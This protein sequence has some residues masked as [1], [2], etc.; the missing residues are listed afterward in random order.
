[1]TSYTSVKLPV[2]LAEIIRG[3]KTFKELG[4]RSVSEFVVEMA[5]REAERK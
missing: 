2:R 4:Y 5:R 1:M 3:C